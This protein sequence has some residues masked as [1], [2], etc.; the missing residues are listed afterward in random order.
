MNTPHVE[1]LGFLVSCQIWQP[2][3]W[4]ERQFDAQARTI[5]GPQDSTHV[6][7]SE[8][9]AEDGRHPAWSSRGVSF[10]YFS[11]PCYSLC[12]IAGN[13]MCACVYCMCVEKKMGK[14]K[15]W[16][17]KGENRAEKIKTQLEVGF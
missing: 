9:F 16:R 1:S 3:Q 12:V 2:A 11:Y 7:S 15:S 8:R 4:V 10:D 17:G 5:V 6:P 14:M 13:A